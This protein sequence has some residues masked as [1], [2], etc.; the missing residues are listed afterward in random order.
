MPFVQRYKR[1]QKS[2]FSIGPNIGLTHKLCGSCLK[3]LTWDSLIAPQFV[4][5]SIV[6]FFFRYGSLRGT[7]KPWFFFGR[8]G[9][10]TDTAHTLRERSTCS[11]SS[12]PLKLNGHSGKLMLWSPLCCSS[13]PLRRP[14]VFQDRV[15]LITKSYP[16][17]Q[18]WLCPR[19]A[20]WDVY[21]AVLHH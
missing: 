4:W 13:C 16:S 17:V 7:G 21:L 10:C 20:V 2:S 5:A 11:S 14:D 19:T 12:W 1:G 8:K 18:G 15:Q 9:C 6:C 3:Y